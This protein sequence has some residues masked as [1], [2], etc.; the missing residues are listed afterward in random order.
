[1]HLFDNLN[2]S[3]ELERNLEILLYANINGSYNTTKTG[4]IL[5]RCQTQKLW[6]SAQEYKQLV[7]YMH[8]TLDG[9]SQTKTRKQ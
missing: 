4:Q 3:P 1:M 2:S 5:Q 7:N 9:G 6:L 8:Y